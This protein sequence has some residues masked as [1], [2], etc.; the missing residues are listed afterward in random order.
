MATS[1]LAVRRTCRRLAVF[2]VC[3]TPNRYKQKC[4]FDHKPGVYAIIIA[5]N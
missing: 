4:N 2:L 1:Y 5:D 3:I